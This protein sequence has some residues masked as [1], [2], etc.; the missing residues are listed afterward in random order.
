MGEWV[1]SGAAQRMSEAGG[2]A[3]NGRVRCERGPDGVFRDPWATADG[4]RGL[5]DFVRWRLQRLRAGVAPDP[6][7]HELPYA[8]PTVVDVAADEVRLTWVGHA[9][10]LLQL[11]GVNVLTDPVWSRR[12]SP[13]SWAGPARIREPGIDF[14]ALP[15]IDA[16]LLSHDHYDHLDRPTVRRLRARFGEALQWVAPLGHAAW[17]RRQGIENAV[18]LDWWESSVVRCAAGELEVSALPARHW[19]RRGP[20]GNR[21]L[22][23]SFALRAAG[24]R[25]YYCGDSGYAPF[26]E[27]VG[28][29][30][31]PFQAAIM[32]IGAY[33]P[34]WFMQPAHMSPDEAVQAYQELG[35]TGVFAAMHWGTFRL[36]DEPPLDPPDRARAAWAAAG[37][38]PE[39]LWVPMHGETKVIEL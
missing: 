37:L 39:K 5:R 4:R 34:R 12:V 22:W 26:F 16:V 6:A 19:T 25:V 21:R 29:A 32:P 27:Q 28:A 35:A 23:A 38:P 14:D 8:R 18:E 33:E 2:I 36:S 13:V 15:P 7:S 1:N 24:A 20:G 11:P 3:E 9:T 30:A 10:F 31:G 17:L